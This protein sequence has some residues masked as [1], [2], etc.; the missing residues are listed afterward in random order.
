MVAFVQKL[1]PGIKTLAI[2]YNP[3]E[4]NNLSIRDRLKEAAR[5]QGITLVEAG[6]DSSADI[7]VRVAALKGKAQALFVPSG[8]MMQPAIPAISASAGQI[9]LPVINSS[10]VSVTNGLTLA[11]YEVD[12]GEVG[13]EAGEIAVKVLKGAKTADIPPV[14]VGAKDYKVFI[15]AKQMKKLGMTLPKGLANCDSVVE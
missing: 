5:K 4:D 1:I 7:P 9:G 12:Y 14:R 15:S 6:C 8:G 10:K 2:I 3:G 13:R 11:G